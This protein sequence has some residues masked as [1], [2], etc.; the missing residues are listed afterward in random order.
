MRLEV[1]RNARDAGRSTS[2]VFR[3]GE[4]G[5]EGLDI[6][7]QAGKRNATNISSEE[8]EERQKSRRAH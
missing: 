5:H 3:C 6:D 8:Q 1:S 4:S 2:E 7:V